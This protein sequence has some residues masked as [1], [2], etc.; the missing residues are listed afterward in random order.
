M[1]T[2]EALYV[3]ARV[4]TFA[5]FSQNISEVQFVSAVT[6]ELASFSQDRDQAVCPI[7]KYFHYILVRGK[8]VR[9]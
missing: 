2:V 3:P 5:D 9:Q 7:V 4:C 8:K 1:V 6:L